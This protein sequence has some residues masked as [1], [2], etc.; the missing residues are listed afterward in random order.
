[1]KPTW[2]EIRGLSLVMTHTAGV[3]DECNRA[4]ATEEK[5]EALN[6]AD[7]ARKADRR[8]YLQRRQAFIE[9]SLSLCGGSR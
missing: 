6:A 9:T 2:A 4:V 1:M 7:I 5:R 8:K 3:T